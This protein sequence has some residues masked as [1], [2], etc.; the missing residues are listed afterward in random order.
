[1]KLS[2]IFG[3]AIAEPD[4]ARR[5][6]PT[7]VD[8]PAKTRLDA[9]IPAIAGARLSANTPGLAGSTWSKLNMAQQIRSSHLF[10]WTSPGHFTCIAPCWAAA[11]L[12]AQFGGASAEYSLGIYL[13]TGAP[14]AH[15]A[16]VTSANPVLTAASTLTQ[17]APGDTI[18]AYAYANTAGYTVQTGPTHLR[19][20]GYGI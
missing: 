2:P 6:Y 10:Q 16:R 19:I 17:Y 9:V 20:E 3:L 11:I 8:D 4:D 13:A 15:L 12:T 5:D 1:M 7:Q 18:A 14:A